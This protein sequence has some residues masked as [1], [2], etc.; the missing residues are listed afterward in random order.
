MRTF[1][2]EDR[3]QVARLDSICEINITCV[4]IQHPMSGTEGESSL[5]TIMATAIDAHVSI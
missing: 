3:F 2:T 1:A 4:Q 5:C